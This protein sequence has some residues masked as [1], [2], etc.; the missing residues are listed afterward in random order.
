MKTWPFPPAAITT[1]PTARPTRQAH[2]RPRALENDRLTHQIQAIHAQSRQTYGSPRVLRELRQQGCRHGRNR[3]ARLMQ[4]AGLC[5]R[6]RRRYR[7]RTTDSNHHE[8]S[9]PNRLATAPKATAPN[10][11][12]VADITYIETAEGWLYLAALLDLSSRKIVGWAMRERS[13]TTLVIH[14]LA[15]ALHHRRPPAQLLCHSDRGVQY[16]SAAYRRALTAAGLLP[17]LSRRGNC[18]DNATME[19][20]WSTLKL[21][22]VYRRK[23]ASRHQAR[24]ALFDY[25]ECFDNRQRAQSAGSPFAR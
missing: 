1:G 8:P 4:V 10:Q 18:Y 20:F 6:Q 23:L 3:I 15:M 24:T 14:A 19:S 13:D 22:L 7:V 17:S 2:P 11:I 12:W 16:A 5:G 21:E 25:V 9:A